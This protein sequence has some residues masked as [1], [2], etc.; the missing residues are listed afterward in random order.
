MAKRPTA[1]PAA[2]YVP[3]FLIACLT[4]AVAVPLWVLDYAGILGPWTGRAPAYWHGHEMVF[5]FALAVVGGYLL[6]RVDR[7]QAALA[8]AAWLIGRL[9]F[10]A[11]GALPPGVA[12]VLALAYPACL[13][14]FGGLPFVKAAKRWHNLVLGPLVGSFFAAES[15]YQ[16][17]AL[18]LVANGEARGLTLAIDLI[19][20]LLFIM[21]GRVIAAATSGAIQ[22]KGDYIK[23]V[24]QNRLERIGVAFLGIVAVIDL[25]DGPAEIS[26]V[27]AAAA[28]AVIVVR[29]ARWQV[30]RVVD[31]LEVSPLHLGYA[32]LAVGLAVRA[33]GGLTGALG[34]FEGDH[35]ITVGA[36]G[37]LS[38]T[39]MTRTAQQRRRR[40]IAM[41]APPLV[42]VLLVTVAAVARLAA[43]EQDH[44][45]QWLAA[46]AAAW[47]LAYVLLAAVLA[48]VAARRPRPR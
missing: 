41:T 38:V 10:F 30:W 44:R 39:M 12:A 22:S 13:F 11:A 3:F 5:G 26:G 8:V 32:W 6:T 19:T 1:P 33:Y 20:L 45:L 28:A 40:R 36:L 18:G 48:T 31:V 35:G 25:L 4:A 14:A 34:P 9:A 15:L 43:V 37:V 2:A 21:G 23:G 16:L 47:S 7:M 27:L 46:A 42:A 24:A 17:G 29:L